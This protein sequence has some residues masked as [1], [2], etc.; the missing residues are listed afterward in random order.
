MNFEKESRL[1][2]DQG[3]SGVD[4]Q[5]DRSS[6]SQNSFQPLP[7]TSAPSTRNNVFFFRVYNHCP[8]FGKEKRTVDKRTIELVQRKN[9]P[10]LC[11]FHPMG[12]T[13]HQ[14]WNI[15]LI[16][17][18]TKLGCPPRP[19]TIVALTRF[20]TVFLKCVHPPLQE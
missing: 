1:K 18:C 4:P 5:S 14:E 9:D 11:R 16:A 2:V 6:F 8:F 17:L 20:S 12:D 3:K 7:N 13:C 15:V 10:F 19:P